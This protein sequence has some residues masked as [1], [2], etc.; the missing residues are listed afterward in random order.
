MAGARP[1]FYDLIAR[2]RRRTWFL[3]FAFFCLLVLV[4]TVISLAMG[5]GIIGVIFAVGISMTLTFTSYWSSA[6]LA[7]SS[8]RAVPADPTEYSRLHNLV[9]EV[10]L[11]AG[12]PSPKVYVV[13]DPSPNA[14]AT[15]RN[16]DNAAV[17][18]TTGLLDK[19]N[20][21]ELEGVI[22]HELA[23]IRNGDILVM[24]VAVATAGSIALISDIFWRMLY[25]G[26]LTGG[27]ASRRRR[28]NNN[29]GGG[30][31]NP[32]IIVGLILVLVLAPIAA[33]LLKAAISRSR[34]SLADATAVKFT[35]YP[36]GLR[37]ALEKLDADITVVRRTSHATSHLWIESP[38][39][40][41]TDSRGRR[42]N[43]MFSTHPPL[44]E[45]IN[46]LREMEGMSPYEG[47]DPATAEAI[48]T[49]QDTRAN[50]EQ[51]MATGGG[52]TASLAGDAAA[53]TVDFE[54]IFGDAGEVADSDEDPTHAAAG[55]YADPAGTAGTLR[56]WDGTSW[57]QHFHQIP[58]HNILAPPDARRAPHRRQ[59][60]R[61]GP[62][63]Q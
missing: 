4:G 30:G 9:Q 23:H 63:R 34:E 18:V 38:D 33:A 53:R 13:H 2:N 43:D 27:G 52:T 57:T 29:S 22:A 37:Q 35:R 44:S 49:Y 56:Y 58:D 55:W 3:M 50:P 54:A 46:L 11:A 39:D 32:I 51:V 59:R 48:R 31:V 25:W 12:I 21:A 61:R 20:R 7:L 36:S 6:S 26:A 16:V 62:V 8:T 19:M 1:D 40:H 41:E 60:R 28:S 17:A 24:T 14:F 42:F 45:R 47:P 10:S 5:G 15:G